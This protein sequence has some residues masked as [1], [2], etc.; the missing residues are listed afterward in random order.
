MLARMVSI[1]WPCDL[2]ASASLSAGIM[3]VS[4]H[5]W[6]YY[7]ILRV[8]CIFWYKPFIRCVF[9][10]SVASFFIL[11]THIPQCTNLTVT[12]LKHTPLSA[13][14]LHSAHTS[15]TQLT[16]QTPKWT[17]L[18]QTHTTYHAHHLPHTLHTHNLLCIH[19]TQT[20]T[21]HHTHTTQCIHLTQVHTCH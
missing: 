20:H 3:G 1:S 14:P 12:H 4:H 13:H 8:L 15:H 10:Q 18:T 17:H 6:P 2:P 7:Q 11:L 19:D 16:T 21:T 5:T 9:S